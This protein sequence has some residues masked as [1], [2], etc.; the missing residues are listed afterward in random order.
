MSFYSEEYGFINK[1]F[2]NFTK[3]YEKAGKFQLTH[4][5][6]EGDF[7]IVHF[8]KDQEHYVEVDV[9]EFEHSLFFGKKMKGRKPYISGYHLNEKYHFEDSFLAISGEGKKF[10]LCYLKDRFNSNNNKLVFLTKKEHAVPISY[11][12]N[13]RNTN[14]HRQEIVGRFNNAISKDYYIGDVLYK[15]TDNFEDYY[16]FTTL[17][18][19]EGNITKRTIRYLH[20][21]GKYHTE[22]PSRR[23]NHTLYKLSKFCVS[24]SIVENAPHDSYPED[25]FSDSKFVLQHILNKENKNL[26]DRS[27]DGVLIRLLRK[28]EEEFVRVLAV[29]FS[30]NDKYYFSPNPEMM[31]LLIDREID[32]Y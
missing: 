3:N 27:D 4:N 17:L 22:Y 28:G 20:M 8:K 18:D 10:Y 32:V 13:D 11:I 5:S 16:E 7:V 26:Y 25:D 9:E 12:N 1:D 6:K 19:F 15:S 29:L 2:N 24:N 31:Q 14:I 21:P 23:K 30:E